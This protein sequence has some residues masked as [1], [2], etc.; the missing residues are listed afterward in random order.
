MAAEAL[1]P[2]VTAIRYRARGRVVVAASDGE[3]LTLHAETVA[4]AEL[5]EGVPLDDARRARIATE[6]QRRAAHEAALRLLAHRPRSKRE[7]AQR[8]HLRGIA[9]EAAADEVE[10]LQRTGLLDDEAFARSWVEERQ[11]SA[12]RGRRLLRHELRA[13]GV[14]A[15]IAEAAVAAADDGEAALALARRRAPRLAGLDFAQFRARLGQFLERRGIGYDEIA[16]AVQ[17]T[18][19][20]TGEPEVRE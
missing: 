13:R 3:T 10:R 1:P 17:T 8:L 4:R 19:D 14:S 11:A 12:P 6:E 9:P 7:L 16:E 2:Q 15:T 20:E 5:R 18:W